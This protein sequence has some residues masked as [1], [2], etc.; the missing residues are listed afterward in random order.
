[1]DFNGLPIVCIASGPSLTAEDC[2]LVLESGLPT[3]AVNCSWEIANFAHVIY[4]GDPQWWVAHHDSINVSANKWSCSASTCDRYR[5][6][7]LFKVGNQAHIIGWNSGMRAIE[8]AKYFGA[9]KVILLG[10]DCSVKNGIHWHGP[11]IKTNNP[12]EAICLKWQK[13]FARIK[14]EIGVPVINCSRYTELTCFEKS[15]LEDELCLQHFP[16]ETHRKT[17]SSLRH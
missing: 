14:K 17:N 7:N 11:H 1:M 2:D 3:I 8:L 4:A 6:V 12:N 15:T 9:S 5:D 10:Y 16:A 13:Q